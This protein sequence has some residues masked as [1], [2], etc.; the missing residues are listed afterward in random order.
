MSL[1]LRSTAVVLTAL[2]L[3]C[4]ALIATSSHEVFSSDVASSTTPAVVQAD[5][6]QLVASAEDCAY[7]AQA[8]A[9]GF[10]ARGLKGVTAARVA[11]ALD[12]IIGLIPGP[13]C[14]RWLAEHGVVP[15]IC[16][17]SSKRF[18]VPG[19]G[20]ARWIVWAVTGGQATQC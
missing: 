10:V 3:L 12:T 11:G 18:W 6:V 7:A 15:T 16:S 17:L 19:R 4:T 9:G 20:T 5:G 13:R 8:I 2:A 1:L 14:G